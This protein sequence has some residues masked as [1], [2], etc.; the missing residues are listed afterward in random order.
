MCYQ[1]RLIKKKEAIQNRF[2]VDID[3]LMSIEDF[4]LIKAF[5]FPKTPIITNTEPNKLQLFQWGLVPEWAQD[6]TIK[7]FTLNARI[8]T[9]DEKPSFKDVIHNRCLILAD[10]FYEWQW[11]TKSGSKKQKY[12]ITLPNE[13]LFAFAGIYSEWKSFDGSSLYSYSMITTQA[14]ELM[15]EIHNTKHRMP[16]ILKKEDEHSWLEGCDYTNFKLP[17]ST[18]LIAT[19]L[20]TD[21]TNQLGLF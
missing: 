3:D 11:L 20:N 18:N 14:N 16:I 8:E 7:K 10:G 4:E 5:D 15:H 6:T 1:T 9:L 21:T 19:A 13:E 17:Y 2:Q 12:L